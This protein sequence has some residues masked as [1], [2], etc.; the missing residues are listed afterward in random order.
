MDETTTVAKSQTKPSEKFKGLMQDFYKTAETSYNG[1]ESLFKNS[2]KDYD[3]ACILYAEDPKIITPEEFFGF[4]SKFVSTFITARQENVAAVAKE[5]QDKKREEAKKVA[6]NK[7]QE[8]KIA[9]QSMATGAAL[10]GLDDLI[11]AIKTGQA[12]NLTSKPPPIGAATLAVPLEKK[13]GVRRQSI[14]GTRPDF[15]PKMSISA[16]ATLPELVKKPTFPN[17]DMGGTSRPKR[18]AERNI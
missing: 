1:L 15:S 2:E 10:G 8:K 6:N 9:R 4:F 13:K 18:T 7:L 11:S 5:V 16:T 3:K 14:L 17:F 12:F